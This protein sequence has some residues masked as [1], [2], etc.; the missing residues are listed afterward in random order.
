MD[1]QNLYPIDRFPPTNS[2][3]AAIKHLPHPGP[4]VAPRCVEIDAGPI[5]GRYRVKFVVRENSEHSPT[6]WFWGVESS[7]R[8]AVGQGGPKN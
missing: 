8:I 7:E 2:L 5:F 6:S 4:D 1:K 3:A